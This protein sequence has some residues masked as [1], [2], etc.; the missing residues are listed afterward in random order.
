[1]SFDLIY[2]N[3]MNTPKM[4][5]ITTTIPDDINNKMNRYVESITPTIY[6]EWCDSI[7]NR[8][9]GSKPDMNMGIYKSIPFNKNSVLS[10]ELNFIK[11]IAYN[12]LIQAGFKIS[13]EEGMIHIDIFNMETENKTPTH[14]T[15]ACDN[16]ISDMYFES[17]VFYTRKDMNV[18]GD[19]DYY[20]VPPTLFTNVAPNVLTTKSNLAVLRN[21]DMHYK[22]QDHSEYGKENIISVHFRTLDPQYNTEGFSF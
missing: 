21:G 16:D 2:T 4:K 1:M 17:C 7:W 22:I 12:L 8:L 10:S 6:D 3:I 15:I 20:M 18:I 11:N 13:Y 14:Y 9:F 5:L 19:L